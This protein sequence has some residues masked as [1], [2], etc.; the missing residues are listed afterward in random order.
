[1]IENRDDV[2]QEKLR[3]CDALVRLSDDLPQHVKY[4]L[5]NCIDN[6]E[7]AL[8]LVEHD[9]E[10]ASFRAITGEEEAASCVIHAIKLRG[11]DEVSRI[12]PNNHIHKNAIIVCVLAIGRELQPILEHFQ[13]HFDFSKVRI[14]LKVPLSNFGV[15]DGADIAFQPVE[16]LDLL[17]SQAGVPEN[18]VFFEALSRLSENSQFQNIAKLVKGRANQ[19]NTLLYASDS[20]VPVS[21]TTVEVICNRRD[22]A[23]ALLVISIMIL[24]SKT[25]L[26]SV[27]QAIPAIKLV[28]GRLPRES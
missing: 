6:F 16:P 28:I 18:E 24:Q 5:R 14:D 3:V 22:R 9:L 19:R 15:E 13:L 21:Q 20:S 23:L 26:A 12:K 7:R 27:K 8:K 17:H 25:H 1:M 2:E 4:R 10:M 11:Y